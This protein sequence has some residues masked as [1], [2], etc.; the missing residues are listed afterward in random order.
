M[1]TENLTIYGEERINCRRGECVTR[2]KEDRKI[3]N[4]KEGEK[5][6]INYMSD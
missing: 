2:K 6:A 3:E 4:E 1:K 5:I